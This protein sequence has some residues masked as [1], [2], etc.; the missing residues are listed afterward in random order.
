M[1]CIMFQWHLYNPGNKLVVFFA[2]ADTDAD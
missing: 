1:I 2:Y